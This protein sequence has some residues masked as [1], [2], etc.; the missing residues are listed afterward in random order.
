MRKMV[1]RAAGLDVHKDQ[2]TACVRIAGNGEEGREEIH[3]FGTTTREL[4]T[5]RDCSPRT[6]SSSW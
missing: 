4:L 3:E 5:L 1:N 2:V 6:M